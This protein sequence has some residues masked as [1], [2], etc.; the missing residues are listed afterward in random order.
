[1]P[2]GTQPIIIKKKVAHSGHHGGAWK[3]AYADFVTA[4]MALFIVLWLMNT[5]KQ[6]QEAVGGYFRDPNGTS[7]VGVG[8]TGN[9]EALLVSKDNMDQLKD[10]LQK[11]MQKLADF[12]KMKDHIE[13]TVTSEG[14][15][16]ELLEDEKGTFF[17]LGSTNPTPEGR[18]LLENLAGEIGKLPNRVAIEGHTDSKPF[19]GRGDY[20]NWELSSDRA[21]VCRRLMMANGLRADQVTQVRGYADQQL[22]RRNDP[23]DPSN[24]RISLIVKYL[25]PTDAEEKTLLPIVPSPATPKA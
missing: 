5:S 25:V 23:L 6:V 4:M 8:G 2:Q 21:N 11:S 24:R 17:D 3:V 22:R 13:M 15:R 14:L 9:G 16:I 12:D 20:S 10:E 18:A 1:M 19:S 7:K